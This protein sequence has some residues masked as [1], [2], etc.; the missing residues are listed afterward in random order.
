M[1][2]R[3]YFADGEAGTIVIWERENKGVIYLNVTVEKNGV[4]IA[5]KERAEILYGRDRIFIE[6]VEK[7]IR[8]DILKNRRLCDYAVY[9]Q[10]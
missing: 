7:D 5:N 8:I 4:T 2:F 1:K 6:L 10:E 3:H 9:G